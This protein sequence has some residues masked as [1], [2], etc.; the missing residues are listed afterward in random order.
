ME[1]NRALSSQLKKDATRI[2]NPRPDI[3][4]ILILQQLYGVIH[5]PDYGFIG[6]K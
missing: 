1:I 4:S 2:V 3:I 6:Y 5:F